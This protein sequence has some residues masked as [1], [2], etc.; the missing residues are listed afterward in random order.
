MITN[1]PQPIKDFLEGLVLCVV[2]AFLILIANALLLLHVPVLIAG[3]I[4]L[5]DLVMY[6]GAGGLLAAAYADFR[7]AVKGAVGK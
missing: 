6:V 7:A 5:F 2:A 3:P 1:L 4:W